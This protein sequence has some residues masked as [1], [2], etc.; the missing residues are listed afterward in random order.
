MKT[1]K[2]FKITKRNETEKHLVYDIEVQGNHNFFANNILV[3]NSNY[4]TLEKVIDKLNV[5]FNSNE[6]FNTWMKT[7]IS[8]VIQ[9][10]IDKALEDYAFEFGLRNIIKFKPEKIIKEMFVVAG[11]NYALSVLSDEKGNT[12]FDEPKIAIT[13]IPVKKK[14]AQKVAQKHLPGILSDIMTGVSRQEIDNKLFKVKEDYMK[15]DSNFNDIFIAGRGN[16]I[17]SYDLSYEYIKEN[18][19]KFK[20]RTPWNV[21]GAIAHNYILKDLGIDSVFPLTD[22]MMF[23]NC[24]VYPNNKYGVNIISWEDEFPKEFEGIFVIDKY[25][26]WEKGIEKMLN[27]WYNVIGWG[28]VNLEFDSETDDF[29]GF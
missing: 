8:D 24:Y 2:N 6:E 7:F 25:T 13:G 23:K 14:T 28:N 4:L 5:K 1:T 11:K 26:M 17:T 27:K 21:K 20:T 3:H 9:P 12:W 18:G 10:Q 22:G 15:Q 19:F 16:D 29:F